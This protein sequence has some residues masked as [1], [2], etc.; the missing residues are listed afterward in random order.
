[1][2]AEYQTGIEDKFDGRWHADKTEIGC[3]IGSA[4]LLVASHFLGETYATFAVMLA[5]VDLAVLQHKAGLAR[6]SKG[7]K[8]TS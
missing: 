3:A 8:K 1:M 5:V 7:Q 4:G 6:G 2:S